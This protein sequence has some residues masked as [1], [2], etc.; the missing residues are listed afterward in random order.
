ME[1]YPFHCH[2]IK[3][4]FAYL[5]LSNEKQNIFVTLNGSN[6]RPPLFLYGIIA[7]HVHIVNAHSGKWNIFQNFTYIFHNI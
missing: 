5:N 1:N 6:F 2:A 3:L 7:I 4:T